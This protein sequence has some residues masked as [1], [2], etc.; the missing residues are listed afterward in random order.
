MMQLQRLPSRPDEWD[1][2]IRK[3]EQKT[4]FHESVWHDYLMS[5]V[6]GARVD[7]FVIVDGAETVGLF[8]A[9]RVTKFALP[10]YGSPL[11][12]TG[13]NYMGP[14]VQS[15]VDQTELARALLRMCR[16]HRIAHLELASPSVDETSLSAAGF[17][18]HRSVTHLVPLASTEEAAWG[19]LRS[20]C[21]NR[22]KKAEKMGVVAEVTDDPT[23][24]DH[25]MAQYEEVYG[26]Q[27][28]VLP[29]GIDRPRA[30]FR[31]L[32]PASRLLPVWVRHEGEIVAAGLFP[33]DER[34]IYFWGAASWLA[35]QHLCPNELL[36]WA[37]M[38]EAVR[39][40]IPAYNMC[41]GTSQFKDK[42][43]GSDVP[44]NHYSRSLVPLLSIARDVYRRLHFQQ[45]R[46]RGL[47]RPRPQASA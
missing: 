19:E 21:R 7:Y 5:I 46:L 47:F 37:V 40:G 16:R 38:R 28:M 36:H 43:G 3:Y 11:P 2:W 42:F 45:L 20:T 12:G 34:A 24:V 14:L 4:L 6:P 25:F 39:R 13:T 23:I 22:V 44:Y 29:F 30:L 9:L 31:Q 18:V 15:G 1:D 10:V 26:K 35:H 8:C 33:Y 32:L 41:G 27:G 17:Q